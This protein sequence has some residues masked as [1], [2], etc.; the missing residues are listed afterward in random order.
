M[1]KYGYIRTQTHDE[2][3]GV[4]QRRAL[5]DVRVEDKNI[6]SDRFSGMTAATSRAG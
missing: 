5:L 6:H 4:F 2:R 3:G 1:S